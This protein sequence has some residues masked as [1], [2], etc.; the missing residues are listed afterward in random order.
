MFGRYNIA[1]FITEI[2]H[3]SSTLE[4]QASA[5]SYSGDKPADICI[6]VPDLFFEKQQKS[7]PHLSDDE[8]YYIWTGFDF[9]RQILRFDAF[10]IHSSCVMYDGYAYMFSADCGTGKSTH[11]SFWQ[12]AFGEDKAKIINDDKPLVIRREGVF[13]AA[14]TPWSG[15]SDKNTNITAPIAAIALLERAPNNIITPISQLEAFKAL[16]KQTYRPNNADDLDRLLALFND[17]VLNVGLF[18]LGCNMSCEAA[19]VSYAAMRPRK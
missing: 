14:G 15:K 11:T 17:F 8:L 6:K 13:Y 2:E 4:K 19:E 1:G 3:G 9:Y 16:F 12:K 5:Y 7:N 18:R 10:V